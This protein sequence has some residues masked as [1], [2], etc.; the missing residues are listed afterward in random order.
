MCALLGADE[1]SAAVGETL[2]VA[3]EQASATS[4][5]YLGDLEAGSSTSLFTYLAYDTGQS[6]LSLMDQVR[7]TYTDVKDVQIAGLP[8]LLDK[9][10][11]NIFP[12]PK[13]WLSL[14][15]TVP[16]KVDA[17][18]VLTS[19]GE[20]AVSRLGSLALPT[21]PPTA[22]TPSF[23]GDAGLVALFPTDIAGS[24]TQVQSMTGQEIAA[25]STDPG[26][27]DQIKQLLASQGKTLDDLSVAFGGISDPYTLIEAV[28]VKGADIHPFV[29]PVIALFLQGQEVQPTPGQVAGK[30]VMVFS[31]NG[32]TS[33]AYPKDDVLWLVFGQEPALSEV[34]G[35]LP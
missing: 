8:A 33:Y 11:L 1:V 20:L 24:P 29:A 23:V 31:A 19:L 28:R 7:G 30:D 15:L 32:S 4:C 35:K 2:T 13:T 12:D 16:D 14:A 10:Q 26:Q 34:I 25:Q 6:T 5:V 21:A 18:K 3:A 22:P 17:T 9:H 27:I